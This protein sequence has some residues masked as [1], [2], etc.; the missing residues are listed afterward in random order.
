MRFTELEERIT[1]RFLTKLTNQI[2]PCKFFESRV[3]WFPNGFVS[4]TSYARIH[5]TKTKKK[6]IG[7]IN[8]LITMWNWKFLWVLLKL[9]IYIFIFILVCLWCVCWVFLFI[10]QQLHLSIGAPLYSFIISLFFYFILHTFNRWKNDYKIRITVINRICSGT[11]LK[12]AGKKTMFKSP[13]LVTVTHMDVIIYDDL[14]Q[15]L[16]K[17]KTAFSCSVLLLN[18]NAACESSRITRIPLYDHR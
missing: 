11:S 14:S 9:W 16:S 3:E 15:R 2:F 7:F 5:L 6:I 8:T 18:Q 1:F 13:I 10:I 17:M 12:V 4:I